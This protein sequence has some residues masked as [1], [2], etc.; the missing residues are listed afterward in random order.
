MDKLKEILQSIKDKGLDVTWLMIRDVKTKEP[1]I[2]FTFFLINNILVL[3]AAL[4]N[5][6]I[7]L[8]LGLN[9]GELKE[10]LVITGAIYFGRM[11]T[12]GTTTTETK[13]E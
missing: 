11:L 8:N 13:G 3:L 4:D 2:T 1:S 10:L 6:R 7:N 5:T 12:S 9:F